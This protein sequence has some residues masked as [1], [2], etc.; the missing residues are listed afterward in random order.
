[1][2]LTGTEI[3][4][5]VALGRIT[6]EPFNTAQVNPNSYNYRIGESYIELSDNSIVDLHFPETNGTKM[7]LSP[8]GTM[9]Q[10]GNIYLCNTQE[11]IGSDYYVTQLIGKS[12]MGRLGLFLQLSADLGHHGE[13]HKWTLEIRP[14][15]P[16]VVYPHMIIGQVTFWK[17]MGS[18]EI[19][20]GYYKDYDLPTL[21]RGI[22]NDSDRK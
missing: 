20:Q 16:I 1:M 21:S 7:S 2:I 6:I 5:N 4:R 8:N 15:I 10:P 13:I 9:L 14:S 17:I 22:E 18:R 12:S 19:S 3:K 11:I